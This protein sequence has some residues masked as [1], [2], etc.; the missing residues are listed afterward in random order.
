MAVPIMIVWLLYGCRLEVMRNSS[1][2][3]LGCH[4]ACGL[5]RASE[6]KTV[7]PHEEYLKS[8]TQH[9]TESLSTS[10][11]LSCKVLQKH[12][13]EQADNMNRWGW[14]GLCANSSN[15]NPS[16]HAIT[17]DT[18]CW[19]CFFFWQSCIEELIPPLSGVP[20]ESV[21]FSVP[22]VSSCRFPCHLCT[23][24]LPCVLS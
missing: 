21:T 17:E 11:V 23:T 15:I 1:A 4:C 6:S 12:P 9:C 8:L 18:N 5:K 3:H 14:P 19:C 13:P 16:L 22:S 20:C 24:H 10:A 7:P 2:D